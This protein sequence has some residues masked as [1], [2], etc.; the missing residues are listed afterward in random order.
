[1]NEKKTLIIEPDRDKL[2]KVSAG[3]AALAVE[4]QR[5][6]GM[7]QDENGYPHP[8]FLAMAMTSCLKVIQIA[9]DCYSNEDLADIC[10]EMKDNMVLPEGPKRNNAGEART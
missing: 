4:M 9:S 5:Q 2:A 6:A 1:M 8:F 3:L 10:Q 7:D